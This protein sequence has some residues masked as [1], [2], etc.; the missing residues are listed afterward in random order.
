MPE[1]PDISGF[2][3]IYNTAYWRA[4][5]ELIAKIPQLEAKTYPSEAG[6]KNQ[7]IIEISNI[8]EDF[9]K[10]ETIEDY[11]E[12]EKDQ[13]IERLKDKMVAIVSKK[14]PIY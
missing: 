10:T 11:T 2:S 13:I 12:N 5:N 7:A 8:L 4:Y 1:K 14:F 6:E 3:G 9:P